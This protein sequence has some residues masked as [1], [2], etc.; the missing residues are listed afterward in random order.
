MTGCVLFL[1]DLDLSDRN[2][3]PIE[4]IPEGN[5]TIAKIKHNIFILY[6]VDR[7]SPYDSW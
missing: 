7:E 2:M 3:Q 4:C 5:T 6:F 1:P